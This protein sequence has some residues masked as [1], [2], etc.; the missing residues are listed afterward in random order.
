MIDKSKTIFKTIEILLFNWYCRPY[1]SSQQ[2]QQ[3]PTLK[4]DC[5]RNNSRDICIRICCPP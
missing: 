3:Q 5:D 4:I 2:Q 1:V